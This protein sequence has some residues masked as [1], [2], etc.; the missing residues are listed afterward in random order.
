MQNDNQLREVDYV[1]QREAG[2]RRRMFVDGY[3]D[4]VVWYDLENSII[5]FE[6]TLNDIAVTYAE[7]RL[8]IHNVDRVEKDNFAPIL[9][10]APDIDFTIVTGYIDSSTDLVD[11]DV[12]AYMR[13]VLTDRESRNRRD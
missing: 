8:S 4:L 11:P 9:K 2:V 6:L 13:A 1:T 5:G 12:V 10:G 3:N 7:G